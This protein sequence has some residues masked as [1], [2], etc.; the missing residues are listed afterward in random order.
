MFTYLNRHKYSNALTEDLWRA[1]GEASGKP[2]EQ[3]MSTWTEQTGFP[4]ISVDVSR[5]GNNTVVNVSQQ[6]FLA[7]G[8]TG[9]HSLK[10]IVLIK[11]I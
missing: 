6:R 1:L 8:S 2:I 7:D 9:Q 11:T 10:N 3:V 4:M 5:D